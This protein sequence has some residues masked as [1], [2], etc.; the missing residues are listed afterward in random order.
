MQISKKQWG[1]ISCVLGGNTVV[2]RV[3][4]KSMYEREDTEGVLLIDVS[5]A[6]NLR[7]TLVNVQRICPAFA[8]VLINTYRA[9][10][11]IYIDGET[12]FSR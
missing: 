10:P 5:N 7:T 2:R 6:F 8:N 1:H 12:I 11:A 9:H 3:A 4:L